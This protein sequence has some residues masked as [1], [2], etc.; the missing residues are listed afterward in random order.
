LL[1]RVPSLLDKSGTFVTGRQATADLSLS[2]ATF[3]TLAPTGPTVA[4]SLHA[5]A[6]NY[7]LR[8]LAQEALTGKMTAIGMPVQLLDAESPPAVTVT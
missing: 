5:A 7:T 3:A 8:V 6:G 2:E 4:L 1:L